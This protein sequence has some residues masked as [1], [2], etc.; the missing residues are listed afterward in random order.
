VEA[1][2]LDEETRGLIQQEV[3]ETK[4]L[5]IDLEAD[6]ERENLELKQMLHME[7]AH[8]TADIEDQVDRV[9]KVRGKVMKEE[10]M[11]RARILGLLTPDQRAE[12][13]DLHQQRRERIRRDYMN[14]RQPRAPAP[15]EEPEP[16]EPPDRF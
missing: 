3:H 16:P 1:L 15:P 11:L 4:L 7:P 10:I 2:G 12:L 8:S 6:V 9:V 14:R 13:E 5:M